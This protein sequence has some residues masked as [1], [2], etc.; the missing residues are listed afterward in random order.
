MKEE[1]Q[2]FEKGNLSINEY[3]MNIKLL[4]DE[5]EGVGCGLSEEEKFMSIL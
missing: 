5:L 2:F 4:T 3:I 1:L